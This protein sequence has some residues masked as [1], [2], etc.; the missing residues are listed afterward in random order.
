MNTAL[1]QFHLLPLAAIMVLVVGC[2]HHVEEKHYEVTPLPPA[3]E[4]VQTILQRYADGR[5]ASS[6]LT[7]FPDLIWSLKKTEHE[8]CAIVQRV[9]ENLLATPERATQLAR[10]AL[11]EI[12]ELEPQK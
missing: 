2:T 11:A 12:E 6:E 9:Y 8:S 10:A 4:R 5:P 1:S 7:L 3:I